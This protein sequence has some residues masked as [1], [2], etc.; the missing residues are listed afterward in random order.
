LIAETDAWEVVTFVDN[1]E[2]V[3]IRYMQPN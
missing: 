2:D 3:P 1:P